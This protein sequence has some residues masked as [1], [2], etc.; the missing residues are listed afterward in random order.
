M[1]VEPPA[2]PPVFA[3]LAKANPANIET[4]MIA[5]IAVADVRLG[6]GIRGVRHA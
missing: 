6:I 5:A 4:I 1:E 2:S 3:S